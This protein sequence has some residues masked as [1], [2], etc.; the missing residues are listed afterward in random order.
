MR[1][2]RSRDVVFMQRALGL[3]RR[4]LGRTWPNPPVGAVFVKGGRVVGEGWHRR[5]GKPHAEIEALRAAGGRARGAVL[6]VTLEPCAHTGRTGPCVEALLPL[7]LARVVVAARDPNPRVRG[8]GIGRL[9]RHGVRVDVGICEAEAQELTAG[10]RTWVVTGRPHVTLKV[11][12]S[13]DGRIAAPGGAAKW[14]TGPS[15]RRAGRAMRAACDA[16]L[17]GAGT[18]RADD[19][20][21][22]ARLPGRPDPVRIVVTGQRVALPSAAR[23]LDGGAPTWL[24]VP[25]GA[26]PARLARLRR[27]GVEIVEVPARRGRMAFDAV[28]RALG[29]RGLT[30]VLVEGGAQ[31]AT[32]ALAAGVVDR[33]AWFVAPKLLGADAVAAIGPLGL[34]RV[35]GAPLLRVE[36]VERLGDDVLCLGRPIRRGPRHVASPRTAR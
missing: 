33:V 19:P 34:R 2:A 18:V 13:L 3:A 29:A 20:R 16:V 6:Y 21:L 32:A 14:I 24:V 15:A 1:G 30:S 35:A 5:A 8:R 26:S 9:R 11:A 17:V 22:T 4:G 12:A 36:R 25:S 27:A 31:V 10:Y 28:V 7:G 23:V